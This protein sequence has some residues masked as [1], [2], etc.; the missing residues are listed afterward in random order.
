MNTIVIK[1]LIDTTR[2]HFNVPVTP[3]GR[4]LHTLDWFMNGKP[5]LSNH[6]DARTQVQDVRG[7]S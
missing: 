4:A 2:K 6:D 5:T 3:R 1:N 7:R